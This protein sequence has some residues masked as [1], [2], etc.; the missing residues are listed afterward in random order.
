[1][2]YFTKEQK[3]ETK[4]NAVKGNYSFITLISF[5]TVKGKNIV[6]LIVYSLKQN[7]TFNLPLKNK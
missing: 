6:D 1:M 3:L 4:Y 2:V 5:P 7:V